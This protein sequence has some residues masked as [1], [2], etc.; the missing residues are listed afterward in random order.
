MERPEALGGVDITVYSAEI[1]E[2]FMGNS[3]PVSVLIYRRGGRIVH[4]EFENPEGMRAGAKCTDNYAMAI[5]VF[6]RMFKDVSP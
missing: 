6:N 5:G 3:V 2:P 4:V 1:R